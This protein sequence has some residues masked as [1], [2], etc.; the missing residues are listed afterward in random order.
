MPF[1]NRFPATSWVWRRFTSP[2]ARRIYLAVVI[3]AFA[4]TATARVRTYVLTR[5]IHA[6][7]NGLQRLQIDQSTGDELLRTVPYLVR[8]QRDRTEG[9]RTVRT[10]SLAISNESDW[11]LLTRFAYALRG[12][13]LPPLRPYTGADWLGFRYLRFRA[14]VILLDGKVSNIGFGIAPEWVAPRQ[15][16]EILAV[17]SF[18]GF[19]SSY[20]RPIDVTS[21]D[22]ESPQD[23]IAGGNE[24]RRLGPRCSKDSL[25]VSYAFDA[26]A[27]LTSRA[28][29]VNLSCFWGLLGC[30]S[31]GQIAPLAWQDKQ[32]IDAAAVAR[33]K[34]AEPCPDRI[35]AGRVRYLLDLDLDL[36]LLEVTNTR[37]ERINEEGRDLDEHYS[38]DRVVENLRGNSQRTWN[39]VRCREWIPSPSDPGHMIFNPARNMLLRPGD[40]EL[41]FTNL[42]IDSCA[43]V[44]GTPSALSV[45]RGAV[46][47]PKRAEDELLPGMLL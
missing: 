4:V 17:E 3:L 44:P 36:L 16:G 45:V 2:F 39:S 18:H 40:R 33:L 28:F 47:A 6:V 37:T 8:G 32:A 12:D 13:W 27:D 30:R 11:L 24:P 38:D 22:D 42:D 34:S 20:R 41:M 7:L 21:S 31:A 10:Y 35:P 46:P 26:P 1:P 15:F 9:S 5:R 43:A 23:R 25:Q 14:E 19:W 29:Q